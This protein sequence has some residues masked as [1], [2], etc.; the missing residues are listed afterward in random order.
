MITLT[1]ISLHLAL[2]LVFYLYGKKFDK[3]T[4]KY[5]I[6][7][8]VPI[9]LFSLEEGLRWGRFIDWCHYYGE[10]YN[11]L[12]DKYEF[13]FREWWTMLSDLRVPYPLVVVQCSLLFILSQFILF[14][15][16][17]GVFRVLMP[18][19]VAYTALDAENYIRW[20]CALSFIFISLRLFLDEKYL[21]AVLVALIVPFMHIGTMPLILVL[22]FAAI[23]KRAIP[24]L[25]VVCFSIFLIFFFQTSYMLN[26]VNVVNLLFGGVEK[27]SGYMSDVGGWLTGTGQNASMERKSIFFYLISMIPLYCIIYG[28]YALIGKQGQRKEYIVMYNLSVFGIVGLSISSGIELFMRY[29]NIFFPF[30]SLLTAYVIIYVKR[31]S[32]KGASI[33]IFVCY[34][35]IL[36]KFYL[37]VCPLA[38]DEFMCYVWNYWLSPLSIQKLY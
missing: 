17:V 36:Y 33:I 20:Y 12:S 35:F 28:A 4:Y 27:F 25:P 6:L 7:A 13:L 34:I 3:G 30:I 9:C 29:T 11:G 8:I 5:W 37:F 26:F 1:Y 23:F 18:L 22:L 16:H 14:R 10:Y 21:Y 2:L 38:R 15:H 31:Y 32:V 24:P 19:V